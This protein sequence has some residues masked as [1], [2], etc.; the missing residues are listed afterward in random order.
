M[1][2][3]LKLRNLLLYLTL[4]ILVLSA[5]TAEAQTRA[6]RYKES[7]Y[8]LNLPSSKW[9]AVE[10]W[11]IGQMRTYFKF[12]PSWKRSRPLRFNGSPVQNK[13]YG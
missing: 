9:Q 12:S 6:Y 5:S 13:G 8:V 1:I 3:S 11:R 7:D 4:L 2:K 10:E